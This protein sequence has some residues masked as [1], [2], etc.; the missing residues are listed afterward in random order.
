L[1]EK[2]PV[3][4]SVGDLI[5]KMIA[6]ELDLEV[7]PFDADLKSLKYELSILKQIFSRFEPEMSQVVL[8]QVIQL[9]AINARLRFVKDRIRQL[10]RQ[11]DFDDEFVTL[12]RENL[13]INDKRADLRSKLND[14]LNSR[15]LEER[16]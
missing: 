6:L 14:S 3:P 10:E 1:S 4:T 7:P 16:S 11:S 15:I 9:R 5:E 12:I 2:V 8:E 13:S